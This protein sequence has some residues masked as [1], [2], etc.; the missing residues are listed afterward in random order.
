[1]EIRYFDPLSRA[2][3]RMKKALFQPFDM[4]KWFVVGFTA[5]LAGLT[6]CHGG[7]GGGGGGRGS[8]DW[9]EV[10]YFPRHAYEWLLDNP[11][12]FMLIVFAIVVIFLLVILFTWLSSR[13][14]FMFLDNVVHDRAQVAK[15][16]YEYS[17]QGNSL[18][19]WSLTVGLFIL[20]IVITYLVY[21]Y[22]VIVDVYEYAW[23][24]A[25][26]IVPV[27]LMVLGFIAIILVAGF[28]DLLLV[29]FVVPIMYRSRLRV[30]SAWGTFL[31]LFGSHVFSFIGYGLFVLVL[32]IL[33]VVGIILAVL[34]TCC[35]GLIFLIIPYIN[36][37]VLLPISY[38]MRAFSVEFLEQFGPE[39]EV[40][41]RTTE[42]QNTGGI[43]VS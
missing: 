17:V 9:D 1:M 20:A 43:V 33:I 4:R 36:A 30:L 19:L 12:W 5:F 31:P 39:Y 35:I 32:S 38:T 6:D 28:V 3:G 42:G 41:P 22:S 23:D 40:F 25:M 7:N 34:F 24:P 21:C 29:D 10:I 13:G 2:F 14:K 15:P 11:Q 18:F 37:V 16:W 26:L 8:V 27:I